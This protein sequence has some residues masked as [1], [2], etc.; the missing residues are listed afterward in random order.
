MRASAFGA[1]LAARQ[2]RGHENLFIAKA[3]FLVRLLIDGRRTRLPAGRMS[4]IHNDRSSLPHCP[5]RRP[6]GADTFALG[7]W[8]AVWKVIIHPPLLRSALK[9]GI[10]G[11]ISTDISTPLPPANRAGSTEAGVCVPGC[12]A[13]RKEWCSNSRSTA[14]IF[15]VLQNPEYR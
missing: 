1:S 12:E 11:Q 15:T 9:L 6:H 10:S 2:R 7:P 8:L 13:P 3:R 4:H 14:I 5:P